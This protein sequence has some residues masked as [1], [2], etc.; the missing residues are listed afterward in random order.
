MKENP[1]REKWSVPWIIGNVVA[2]I[3][4]VKVLTKVALIIFNFTVERT[5][6]SYGVNFR[7]SV[8]L[9]SN[10][11]GIVL[12][13]DHVLGY[14]VQVTITEC[15]FVSNIAPTIAQLY[16]YTSFQQLF[17]FGEGL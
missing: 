7:P 9:Y 14:D 17:L 4:F 3:L 5:K 8:S 6:I 10:G 2:V 1:C 12:H 13:L 11:A 16:N 15:Y